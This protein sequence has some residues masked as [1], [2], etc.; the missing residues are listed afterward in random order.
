MKTIDLNEPEEALRQ[1]VEMLDNTNVHIFA[2]TLLNK[3]LIAA[4]AALSDT[5]PSA[6]RATLREAARVDIAEMQD[7]T[8]A[9]RVEKA[10]ELILTE[11]KATAAIIPFPPK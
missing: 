6:I 3:Y 2:L 4:I 5:N 10:L 11:P 1:T 8:S 7:M 9:A